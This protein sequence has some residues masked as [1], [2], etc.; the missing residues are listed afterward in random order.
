MC[1]A[2]ILN[3]EVKVG[4]AL[5]T[6]LVG[7]LTSSLNFRLGT[8]NGMHHYPTNQIF[9]L[10]YFRSKLRRAKLAKVYGWEGCQSLPF[11]CQSQQL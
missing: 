10:K 1:R 11:P 8:L 2:A 9:N 3:L 6:F 4:E 7:N 5:L